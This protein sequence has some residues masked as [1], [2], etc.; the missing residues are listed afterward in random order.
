MLQNFTAV[1]ALQVSQ[2]AGDRALCRRRRE[3][4]MG[5]KQA[6]MRWGQPGQ[7]ASQNPH[8]TTGEPVGGRQGPLP[9]KEGN[10]HG[11]QV[12]KHAVGAAG[13]EGKPRVR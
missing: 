9:T 10:N 7:K 3:T 11:T 8:S 6:S 12:G 13:A 4:I 5:L 2:L 1:T